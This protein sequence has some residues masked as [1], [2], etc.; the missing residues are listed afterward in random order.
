MALKLSFF[1]HVT[2]SSFRGRTFFFR[3]PAPRR[4]VSSPSFGTTIPS[5]KLCRIPTPPG[6]RSFVAP[7]EHSSVYLT[8]AGSVEIHENAIVVDRKIMI[9]R[10]LIA[11]AINLRGPSPSFTMRARARKKSSR[12][13]YF[14]SP[15]GN[16]SNVMWKKNLNSTLRREKKKKNR[17]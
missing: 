4:K 7:V 6:L 8:L 5:G 11:P 14:A 3:L 10:E 12:K 16:S 1:A 17:F 13:S 9:G 2:L 15:L